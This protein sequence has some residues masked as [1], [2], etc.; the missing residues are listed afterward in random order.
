MFLEQQ[1]VEREQEREEAVEQLQ[2]LKAALSEREKECERGKNYTEQLAAD[3]Q[4]LHEGLKDRD[5]LIQ[6]EMS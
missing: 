4:H 6:V 2:L 1:T 3:V 5:I